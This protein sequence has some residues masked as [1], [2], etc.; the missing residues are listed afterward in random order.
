[1]HELVGQSRLRVLP[2]I[3]NSCHELTV[4]CVIHSTSPGRVLVDCLEKPTCGLI[5][6]S[7]CNL[8]FGEPG[9]PEFLREIIP[10]IEY[11]DT[12]TCDQDAWEDVVPGLHRNPALRRYRREYAALAPADAPSRA[13]SV[14]V[15]I[16]MVYDP[17][18][19]SL[20]YTNCNLVTEWICM[21]AAE[22]RKG[23]PLAAL[24]IEHESIASC[25]AVDC[26]YEGR[27]EIGIKTQREF[28]GKGYGRATTGALVIE[29]LKHGIK[30]IGWHCVGTNRGSMRIAVRCGFS[31]F[32]PYYS[33][34]PYPPIENST[35][36]SKDEWT[37]YACFLESKAGVDLSQYWQA[38]R[39]WAQADDMTRCL[40]SLQKL[41]D[42]GMDWFAGL[43]KD[44][45]EFERFAMTTEW[46]EFLATVRST[47]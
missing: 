38:A 2:L 17:D 44:C 21:D 46:S 35:D 22:R 28:R 19:E 20:P 36:L 11:Y 45:E 40:G 9:N 7:E 6:T 26:H 18:L 24:W 42:N 31:R 43:I 3:E 12:L 10:C 33:Y 29:S 13:E 23:F 39:C 15:N 32:L 37:E 4:T 1:M 16:R 30:E 25:S 5:K 27:I 8:L 14:P 34:S 47:P 41:H